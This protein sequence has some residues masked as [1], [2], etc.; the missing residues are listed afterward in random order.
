MRLEAQASAGRIVKIASRLLASPSFASKTAV[1]FVL[2]LLPCGLVYVALV[3]AVESGSALGGAATMAGFGAGTALGLLALGL[4]STLMP[5][6]PRRWSR[7]VTAWATLA[8][9]AVLLWRGLAPV[10]LHPVAEAPAE[11]QMHVH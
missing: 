8:L 10:H 3:K 7:P 5:A 4:A 2:G 11:Q 1:G 9:G 6:A